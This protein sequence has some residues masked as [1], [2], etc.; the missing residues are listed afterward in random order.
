MADHATY[1][2]SDYES[3][4]GYF[5]V[6]K[7]PHGTCQRCRQPATI[8]MYRPYDSVGRRFCSDCEILEYLDAAVNG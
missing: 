7:Y 3:E 2:P 4:N 5:K 6:Y 8:V 1:R